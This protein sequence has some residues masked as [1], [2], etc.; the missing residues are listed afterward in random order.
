MKDIEKT[1]EAFGL[2]MD[3]QMLFKRLD[4][5]GICLQLGADPKTLDRLVF[6]E[7]GYRGQALVDLYRSISGN[8]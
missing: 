6:M 4:F 5:N 1:Y 2:A 3:G 8:Q 7:L